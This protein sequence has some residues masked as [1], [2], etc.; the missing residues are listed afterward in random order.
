MICNDFLLNIHLLLIEAFGSSN[1]ISFLG[2]AVM[3]AGDLYSTG[4][5]S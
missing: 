1:G 4:T 3:V 2:I 5:S